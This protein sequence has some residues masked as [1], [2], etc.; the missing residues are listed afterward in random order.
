[1][2]SWPTVQIAMGPNRRAQEREAL[3]RER[4]EI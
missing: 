2:M 1:M 3:L 4:D